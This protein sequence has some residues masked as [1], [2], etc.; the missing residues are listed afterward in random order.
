MLANNRTLY[1]SIGYNSLWTC[2]HKH[3]VQLTKLHKFSDTKMKCNSYNMDRNTTKPISA[4]IQRV[5]N[6]TFITGNGAFAE[7]NTLWWE[8]NLGLSAE[9]SSTR[10]KKI[11]L[12]EENNSRWRNSSSRAK[13]KL[14]VRNSL[15]EEI[16]H[17]EFFFLAL[18][19]V[20]LTNSLFHL[21]TFFII[22]MH[23]YKGYV[24]IWRNFISVCYI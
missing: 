6:C 16:L 12:G 22:N 13:E 3:K 18:G 21:Q 5:A 20:I 1:S 14:S 2:L 7:S 11:I 15:G 8:P 4:C 24:Q 17:R 9:N 19:E 23:L 10:V